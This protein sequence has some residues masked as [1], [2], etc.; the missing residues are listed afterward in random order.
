MDQP[1]TGQGDRG[2]IWNVVINS[3]YELPY[4]YI[5]SLQLA[6]SEVLG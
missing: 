2:Q 5:L 4:V 1:K 3:S 6:E